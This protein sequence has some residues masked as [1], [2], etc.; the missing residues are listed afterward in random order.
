M[1]HLPDMIDDEARD[2]ILDQFRQC[3]GAKRDDRRAAGE[4]FHHDE[5]T[6]FRR[7]ARR[8]QASCRLQQPPLSAK[9]ERAEEPCAL[10]LVLGI[11][12]NRPRQRNGYA[13]GSSG[14]DGLMKILFRANA[15]QR[16]R[17]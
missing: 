13:G 8:Q 3:A 5:R 11:S 12:E 1:S 2:A 7:H 15:A 14:V 16:Q 6:G 4:R 17:V 10:F 9:C